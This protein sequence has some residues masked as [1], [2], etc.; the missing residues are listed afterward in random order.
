MFSDT[1]RMTFTPTID[2]RYTKNGRSPSN[3]CST[4]STAIAITTGRIPRSQAG[5]RYT[6]SAA[7]L[8]KSPPGRTSSTMIRKPKATASRQLL[9]E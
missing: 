8:P 2:A 5:M 4:R 9:E 7:T 1:A 3:I 6:F